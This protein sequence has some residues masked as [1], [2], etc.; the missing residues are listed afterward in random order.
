MR[1]WWNKS[2]LERR[3]FC[4]QGNW[5]ELIKILNV[6]KNKRHRNRSIVKSLR[7]THTKCTTV[8]GMGW[9]EA[10]RMRKLES[11][12]R[13]IGCTKWRK[14]RWAMSLMIWGKQLEN[15]FC[16]RICCPWH[17][18]IP[19]VQPRVLTYVFPF[20]FEDVSFFHLGK[21]YPIIA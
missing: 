9:E 5:F 10:P 6:V 8:Y 1:S 12:M 2:N 20:K 4:L 13:A 15:I 21:L 3:M 11:V 17:S 18:E 7:D 19:P 16:I 14:S